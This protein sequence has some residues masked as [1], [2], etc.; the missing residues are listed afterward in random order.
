MLGDSDEECVEHLCCLSSPSQ[1]S[2]SQGCPTDTSQLL[3]S[4]VKG[5]L[6]YTLYD[7]TG[8]PHPRGEAG[9]IRGNS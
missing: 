9:S 3:N 1:M 7:V 6:G 2:S 4:L 5:D 8:K